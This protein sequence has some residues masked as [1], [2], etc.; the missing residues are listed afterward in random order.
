VKVCVVG[1]TGN[2]S[3][4]IVR[5][6]LSDGHEVVCCNRGVQGG[7]PEGARLVKIDRREDRAAFERRMQEEAF[8]AAV[9]MICFDAEDAASSIRA[10]RGVGHFVT[11]STVC[12]YGVRYD[13]MPTTEDHPLRPISDYGRGKVAADHLFL[14]EYHESGFPVTVIKPST[15][16]GPRMGLLRQVAWDLSWVDRV[17][18]GVPIVVCGDGFA[19]HQFLHVEDAALCFAGVLKHDVCI[20]Q[21]YN[22]VDRGFVTWGEYH[23]TA[24]KVIG[25]EVEMVGVPFET[26]RTRDIP[27]FEICE[28]VFAYSHYYSAEK[29]FRDVPEFRPCF[30]LERAI[31]EIL[32]H[33][34]QEGR[35]PDSASTQWEDEIIADQLKVRR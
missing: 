32:E 21:V 19:M 14:K 22:M 5:Q 17:R 28:S 13:W 35:I 3:T 23:R 8:D 27:D 9:D 25:R 12:T 7:L 18:R 26:L 30:T 16:F 1:G 15:T 24:M 11:C 31:A 33:L 29:L 6:L 20:G 2:I 4:S 34:D 10:F